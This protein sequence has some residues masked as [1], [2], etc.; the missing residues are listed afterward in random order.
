[1]PEWCEWHWNCLLTKGTTEYWIAVG[2]LKIF[3]K[4]LRPWSELCHKSSLDLSCCSPY[5]E[6]VST[7]MTNLLN[8]A[9]IHH[10]ES[11]VQ[12]LY[13][14]D[15]LLFYLKT[16]Q[17]SKCLAFESRVSLWGDGTIS[18]NKSR[19]LL[20]KPVAQ[21]HS[22]RPA[23]VLSSWDRTNWTSHV[24]GA[25]WHRLTL[26]TEVTQLPQSDSNPCLN[27]LRAN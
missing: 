14:S 21:S 3:H 17:E 12:Y 19:P 5:L 8:T 25:E 6:W 13:S 10:K 2:N 15:S 4:D 24:S 22:L 26:Q 11:Q 23:V 1:M 18:N 7:A 9:M 27:K 20:I 16:S